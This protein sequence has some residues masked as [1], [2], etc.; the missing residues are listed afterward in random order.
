MPRRRGGGFGMGAPKS[1]PSPSRGFGGTSR[2]IS[3]APSAAPPVPMKPQ[4]PAVAPTQ[5]SMMSQIATTAAG[6]A[7]G[8]TVGHALV[9]SLGGGGSGEEVQQAAPSQGYMDQQ[10]ISQPTQQQAGAVPCAKEL[11]DFIKCTQT[12]SDLK[13]CEGLNYM[14][15]QCKM[16][17]GFA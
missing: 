15:K 12:S 17:Q 11:E 4:V 9:G 7:I 14:F 1:S 5:P 10:Q 3:T 16:D 6:V 8:H 2:P 13:F